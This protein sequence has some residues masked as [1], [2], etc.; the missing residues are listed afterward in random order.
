MFGFSGVRTIDLF[1][2]RLVLIFLETV[3]QENLVA[4][5]KSKHAVFPNS[6]LD[7]ASLPLKRF[8]EP[9]HSI[10]PMLLKPLKGPHEF[11]MRVSILFLQP[12]E[13]F[14]GWVAPCCPFGKTKFVHLASSQPPKDFS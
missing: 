3:S 2:R 9:G 12:I 5:S 7:D 14:I 4:D 13:E 11:V 6:E 10:R 1:L 8:E